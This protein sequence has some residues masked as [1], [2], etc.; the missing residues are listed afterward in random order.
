MFPRMSREI[1]RVIVLVAAEVEFLMTFSAVEVFDLVF[2]P[3]TLLLT[4]VPNAD[5]IV[6]VMA[7]MDTVMSEHEFL[8]VCSRYGVPY[9]IKSMKTLNLPSSLTSIGSE[10]FSG[11]SSV[12]AVRIPSGVTTVAPDAFT[13]IPV[14]FLIGEEGKAAQAYASEHENCIF[15]SDSLLDAGM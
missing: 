9:G 6:A 7:V 1:S 8:T 4:A 13:G 2:L 11:L 14:L 12:E 15:I 5:A 10:A 3:V